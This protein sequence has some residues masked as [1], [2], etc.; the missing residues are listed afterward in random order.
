MDQSQGLYVRSPPHE[1]SLTQQTITG[2]PTLNESS[3][4]HTD[5]LVSQFSL[6]P[7]TQT[8]VTTTTTTI[9]TTFPPIVFRK[10]R[11]RLS[12]F[13]S[14]AYPLKDAPTPAPLKKFKFFVDGCPAVFSESDDTERSLMEVGATLLLVIEK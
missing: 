12:D 13:D 1:V 4:L 10:P 8:R 3:T 6:R 2:T 9:S 5:R 7:V 14:N 11:R